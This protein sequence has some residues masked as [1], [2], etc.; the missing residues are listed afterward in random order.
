M[1][2]HLSSKCG[3][4]VHVTSGDLATS[5]PDLFYHGENAKR[6]VAG[7]GAM[8]T[9]TSLAHKGVN[10]SARDSNLDFQNSSLVDVGRGLGEI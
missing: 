7:M 4:R 6:P 2:V 3:Q 5:F 10:P 8:F 9:F 1:D